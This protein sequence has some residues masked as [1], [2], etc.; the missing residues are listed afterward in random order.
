[1]ADPIFQAERFGKA[2]VALIRGCLNALAEAQK[3]MINAKSIATAKLGFLVHSALGGKSTRAKLDS[4]LPY[5]INKSNG[6][7]K[8]TTVTAIKWALKNEKMPPVI[9]GLIGAELC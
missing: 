4:F 2:P 8:D 3:D 6:V 7:V 9:I 1:M 5:E